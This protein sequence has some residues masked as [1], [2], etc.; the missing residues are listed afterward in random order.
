MDPNN[1]T[2]EDFVC[3]ESFR[4]YC[5][6]SRLSDVQFWEAWINNNPQKNADVQEARQLIEILNAKQGN[7]QEQLSQLKDGIERFD[8]FKERLSGKTSE[9]V[10]GFNAT[11]PRTIR[12]KYIAGIAAS[13]LAVSLVTWFLFSRKETKQPE[14]VAQIQIQ[15]GGEPRKTVVL[16]DGS[17]VTLH[18]NSTIT[19]LNFSKT[20]RELVLSGEAFFDVTHNEQ[21]PFIV[22]TAN[23]N[24]EVLGTLFNVNAYPQSGYTET[25][26]FRGKVAVSVKDHPEQRVILVP[27]Q[28]LV[29]A[30]NA[31]KNE[32]QVKDSSYK[33]MPLAADPVNHKATEIAW[34]R[35]RI[36]IVDEPLETIAA[37]LQSWYGISIVFTDEQVKGYRYSGTFESETVVK[38]LEAL[39]LSYPFNFRFEN[40]KIVISK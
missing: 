3:D 33:I 32:P 12:L 9:P 8:L 23:V 31:I 2:T 25:S 30:N 24:V 10:T 11:R 15:S 7:L 14:T 19:L 13:L 34:V 18:S 40:E 37:K 28:K 5:T 1:Y 36:K 22:H 21:H 38:A 27:S 16:P 39:Q 4:N 6:G 35:N 17:V 20:N 29:I 26:L